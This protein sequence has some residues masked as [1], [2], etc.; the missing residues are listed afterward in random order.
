MAKRKKDFAV[1]VRVDADTI[2]AIDEIAEQWGVS[3]SRV[4]R[5]YLAYLSGTTVKKVREMNKQ[6]EKITHMLEAGSHLLDVATEESVKRR[7]AFIATKTLQHQLSLMT[8]RGKGKR[9]NN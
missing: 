4:V 2:A 7:K 6:I 3:R 8:T 1:N 9:V 5:E